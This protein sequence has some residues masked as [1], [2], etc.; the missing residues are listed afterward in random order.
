MVVQLVERSP[1]K[2]EVG[3]SNPPRPTTI[4]PGA[5]VDNGNGFW[6][7][8]IAGSNPAPV[9]IHPL[10]SGK[11]KGL[12]IPRFGFVG[13]SPTGCTMDG[14]LSGQKE[15]TLNLPRKLRGFESHTVL[16]VVR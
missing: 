2:A 15:Q 6:P 9:A 8:T 14:F 7:R 13:S 4:E 16:D 11:I 10:I 1:D 12:L 5:R 3:G